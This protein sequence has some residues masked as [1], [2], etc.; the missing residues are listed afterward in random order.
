MSVK[1]QFDRY[2][3]YRLYMKK[4]KRVIINIDILHLN[5]ILIE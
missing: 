5:L 3:M 4:R 1:F 2:N